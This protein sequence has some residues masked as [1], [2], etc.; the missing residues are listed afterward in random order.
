MQWTKKCY[1]S[2]TQFCKS[3]HKDN[4]KG[5]ICSGSIMNTSVVCHATLLCEAL[6]IQVLSMLLCLYSNYTGFMCFCIIMNITLLHLHINDLC[7]S[8]LFLDNHFLCTA[9]K[10]ISLFCIYFLLIL[11]CYSLCFGKSICTVYVISLMFL[12]ES[13]FAVKLCSSGPNW[14]PGRPGIC[15]VGRC[16]EGR[17]EVARIQVQGQMW[18][19]GR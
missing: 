7:C 8:S 1:Y 5:Q 16:L 17:H 3:K 19:E 14:R 15:P 4:P 2:A 18:L 9:K 12:L 6:N 10:C 11:K 13:Y